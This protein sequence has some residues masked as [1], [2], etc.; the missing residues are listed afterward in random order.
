[1]VEEILGGING[2]DIKAGI[3]KVA[4]DSIDSASDCKLLEAAAIAQL[5]TGVGITTHTCSLDVRSEVL[6]YL[7]RAGVDPSRIHLGHAGA[8][9]DIAESV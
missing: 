7:E 4:I 1:M 5:E 2:T 6:N 8:K 9:S 3:I